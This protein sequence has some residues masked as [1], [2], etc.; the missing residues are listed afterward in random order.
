MSSVSVLFSSKG[1]FYH[2][3]T[4]REIYFLKD[5]F[6]H[7]E[8][9]SRISKTAALFSD[10]YFFRAEKGTSSYPARP[11]SLEFDE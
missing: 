1:I 3:T 8:E 7:I 11:G 9:T 6:I 2:E 5:V 4:K 10:A